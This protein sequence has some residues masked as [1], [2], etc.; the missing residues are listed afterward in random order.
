[1][2]AVVFEKHGPPEVLKI[3]DL[4][5]PRPGPVQVRVRVRAAGIQPFDTGVRQGSLSYPV[6][7][8]QQLGNEFSGV[9]DQVGEDVSEWSEGDEVLGWALM[10]SLAEYVVAGADAIVHKPADMPWE[11]AGGL[12]SSGQTAYTALRELKVSSDETVLIHAAAGGVGTVAVQLARAW[13]AEVIGTPREANHEYLTS[14]GAI[15]V[16]YG[17]GLIKRV[18]AAAPAGMHAALDAIG[19]QALRDSLA[20]VRDKNRIVIIVDHEVADKLGVR[21]VRAR[22]SVNQLKE[23]VTLYQKGALHILIRAR[24]PLEESST[25]TVRLRSATEEEKSSSRS[26]MESEPHTLRPPH[27][28]RRDPRHLVGYV[29]PLRTADR[30]RY[31]PDYPM[32]DLNLGVELTTRLFPHHQQL[33][34]ALAKYMEQIPFHRWKHIE[35]F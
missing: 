17:T 20:L 25:R 30:P 12:S 31:G 11:V 6:N 5:K 9:V 34:A 19:G 22:R 4:E 13:G 29:H 23:L 35:Q 21:G 14:L 32:R 26:V 18:R 8:P 33:V 7:F 27:H 1:M 2:K 24:F 3:I 15:P 28:H 10:A 16:A